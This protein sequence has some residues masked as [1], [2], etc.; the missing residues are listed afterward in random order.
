MSLKMEDV[1]HACFEPMVPVYQ[2]AMRGRS[3]KTAQEVRTAFYKS[4]S[5]AQSALF[6]F[7]SYYDHASKSIDE[8]QRI[9]SYYR[10]AQIFEAVKSGIDYFHDKDMLHLLMEIEEAM[11]EK[12]GRKLSELYGR[13][14]EISSHTLAIIGGCIR[15]NPA[16]FICFE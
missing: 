1:G 7:F 8:F 4:L 13:L 11:S 16:E 15:E 2:N 3:G 12:E 9:T 6:M 10:S 5:P 14:H